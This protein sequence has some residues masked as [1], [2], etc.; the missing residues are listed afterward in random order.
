MQEILSYSE[1]ETLFKSWKLQSLR[2]LTFVLLGVGLFLIAEFLVIGY[3]IDP[4]EASEIVFLTPIG[5]ILIL[6]SFFVNR[7]REQYKIGAKEIKQLALYKSFE[8]MGI[9][10]P[11]LYLRQTGKNNETVPALLVI[12][13]EF[14][15]IKLLKEGYPDYKRFN[16]GEISWSFTE[17]YKNLDIVFKERFYIKD[18]SRRHLFIM[19]KGTQKKFIDYLQLEMY[20][21]EIIKK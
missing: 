3:I 14:I 20:H 6:A 16:K 5:G 13:E 2:Y 11:V 10:F 12:E 21:V 9:K 1:T 17:Q 15:T 8:T 7:T 18:H 19:F 4:L